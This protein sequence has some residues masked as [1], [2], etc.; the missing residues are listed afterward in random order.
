MTSIKPEF[1]IMSSGFRSGSL[2]HLIYYESIV[3][4]PTL[5]IFGETDNIIPNDM[6]MMLSETFAEPEI[7]VHPGGHYF[8]ATAQQKQF[9]I[10]FLQNRLQDYL[11]RKE[12]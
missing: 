4:I 3:E 5:H 7:L 2:A 1:A 12:L 8:P 11:E 6:S 10:R 9:F